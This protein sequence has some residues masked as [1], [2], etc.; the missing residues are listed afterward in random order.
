MARVSFTLRRS[1][2]DRGSYVRFDTD[3][4]DT[5][6]SAGNSASA[7]TWTYAADRDSDASLRSDGYQLPPIEYVES[8]LEAFP[9]T[10]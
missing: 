2:V 6:A 1:T 10:Y 4:Y 7:G 9:V 3:T 5:A 8:Y